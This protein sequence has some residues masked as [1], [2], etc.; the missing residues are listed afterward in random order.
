M[1]GDLEHRAEDRGVGEEAA[2]GEPEM[3]SERNLDIDLI[4]GQRVP[5]EG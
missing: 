1:E 5:G 3:K 2:D 4:A